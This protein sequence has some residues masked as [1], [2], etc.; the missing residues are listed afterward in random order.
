MSQIGG[1]EAGV[2]ASGARNRLAAA[3][4][5]VIGLEALFMILFLIIW[6]V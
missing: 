4:L 1:G 5:G 3:P 2:P 6:R